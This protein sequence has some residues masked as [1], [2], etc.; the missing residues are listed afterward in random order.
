MGKITYRYGAMNASKSANALILA[1][2]YEESG[3]KILLAKSAKDTRSDGTVHS[4]VGI[5]RSVDVLINPNESVYNKF[6]KILVN[7]PYTYDAIII[8]EAQFLDVYQVEDIVDISYDFDI[9]VIAYGLKGDFQGK[10]FEGSACFMAHA[11]TIEEVPTICSHCGTT[12]KKAR[13]NMRLVDGRPVFEGEQVLIGREESY[14]S[15][16]RECFYKAKRDHKMSKL[17]ESIMST[18]KI[19]IDFDGTIVN[20]TKAF[21]DVYNLIYAD[22]IIEGKATKADW[23]GVDKW[24][25]SDQCPLLKEDEIPHMK[26]FESEKFFNVLEFFPMAKETLEEWSKQGY[27]IIICTNATPKNAI[28]KIHWINLE[29]P[30]ADVIPII[31]NSSKGYGKEMIDMSDAIFI[32]DHAGNLNTSSAK[33][34]ICFGE[35]KEWNKS[36]SPSIIKVEDWVVLKELVSEFIQ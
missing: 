26:I 18:K 12:K 4:R 22:S 19:Y 23:N 10:P 36:L 5:E 9:H 34:P 11:D 21:C 6:R 7:C 20:S 29:I 17:S 31:S 2:N 8:D 28:K 27:N 14:V 13:Y 1:H 35:T 15:V 25:L 3:G 33:I 24:D 30:F 32:D 16:C